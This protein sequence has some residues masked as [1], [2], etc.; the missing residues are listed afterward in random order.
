MIKKLLY[1]FSLTAYSYFPTDEEGLVHV[2]R[3]IRKND[4]NQYSTDVVQDDV[5]TSKDEEVVYQSGKLKRSSGKTSFQLVNTTESSDKE[6][7]ALSN[8]FSASGSYI[9]RLNTCNRFSQTSFF[10]YKRKLYSQMK[11]GMKVENLQASVNKGN[12]YI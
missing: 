10:L 7:I 3:T 4:V 6:P 2:K 9:M 1:L 11:Q 5:D 8:A 12:N